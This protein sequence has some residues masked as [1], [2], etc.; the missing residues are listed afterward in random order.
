[1]ANHTLQQRSVA[2]VLQELKT[3]LRDFATTRFEML[4]A[5]IG[6]KISAWKAALPML[7]A[8]ALLLIVA[9]LAFSFGLAALIASLVGGPFAWVWGAAGV[10]LLYLLIGAVLLWF[11]IREIQSEGIA[12]NRTMR[13]LKEDQVWMKN[14]ART[15]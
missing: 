1:V 8:G 9:F 4:K 2:D 10:T 6:E 13:V 15:A 12:P 3:E 5:E 14:E 11:G 7:I